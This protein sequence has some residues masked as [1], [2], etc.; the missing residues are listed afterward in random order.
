MWLVLRPAAVLVLIGVV[1]GTAGG[2]AIAKVLQ[3]GSLGLAPLQLGIVVPVALLFSG[4]ALLAGW[5][6][7]RRAALADPVDSIRRE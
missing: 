5:L 1:I 7:A 6:P 4:V 2:T 3:A